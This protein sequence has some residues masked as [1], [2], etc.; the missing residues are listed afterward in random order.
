M[1][2]LV[3]SILLAFAFCAAGCG[4]QSDAPPAPRVVDGV[5][6]LSGWDFQSHGPVELNG[7]WDFYWKRFV[8]PGDFTAELEPPSRITVPGKWNGKIE[9]G[10]TLSSDGYATYRLRIKLDPAKL[11]GTGTDSL[12]AFRFGRMYT[13]YTLYLNGEQLA[14][15]GQIGSTAAQGRPRYQIVMQTIVVTEP[16]LDLVL[17]I[18]NY[19][20]LKGGLPVALIFGTEANI[21]G[22]RESRLAFDL[23]LIGGLLVLGIY[24]L[25]LYL[26]SE[27]DRAPVLLGVFC[28]IVALRHFIDDERYVDHVFQNIPWHILHRLAYAA[29]ALAVIVMLEHIHRF[30]EREA[31]VWITRPLQA[32]ST[33]FL[34]IVLLGSPKT[35]SA[36]AIFFEITAV[37]SGLYLI[38]VV[39]FA[40]VRKRN[41]ALM[42][43]ASLLFLVPGMVDKIMFDR[44]HWSGM[45]LLP[46]G[47][48]GFLVTQTL[49][50]SK[51]FSRSFISIEKSSRELERRVA[52]RTRELQESRDE[53]TEA[54]DRAEDS[55]RAKSEFLATMSHEIRTPLN[56]IIGASQL[57]GEGELLRNDREKYVDVLI[58]AGKNLLRLINQVLDFSRLEEGQTRLAR[59]EFAP[60]ELVREVVK[61]MEI[62]AGAKGLEIQTEVELDES[63]SFI[64]DPDRITQIL[65]NLVGNAVKFTGAGRI[66]L[67]LQSL[68]DF[69]GSGDPALRFEVEDTGPGIPAEKVASI[70]DR[71]TQVDSSDSR[72]FEGTGLGLAITK[73]LVHLMNGEIQYR[74]PQSGSGSCFIVTLPAQISGADS[75]KS[76][77]ESAV[78]ASAN[79]TVFGWSPRV[80]LAEDNADNVLLIQAFLKRSGVILEIAP[81]GRKAVELFASASANPGTAYDLILMDIQ[82]PHMDGYAATRRVREIEVSQ[83]SV[84]TPIVALTANA[85]A[86]DVLRSEAAGCDAHLSKP[87]LKAVLL[88]AIQKYAR[89][90]D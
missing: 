78:S 5:I 22:G 59:I 48:F 77:D 53:L 43:V 12:Y 24:Q 10:E 56:A 80:L 21:R 2:G 79:P 47:M 15:V 11:G 65:T 39:A 76:M 29:F 27:V 88:D 51:R 49:A 82:M 50:V 58:R 35:Y 1:P 14:R 87:I 61:M 60:A 54:R 37:V 23:F 6:D 45:D 74:L 32:L 66:I 33:A 3:V 70:F 90:R 4:R 17:H 7:T 63:R 83:K 68:R 73:K 9:A 18:S 25:G 30:F 44:G 31:V 55:N 16:A 84:P 52:V 81:N 34:A 75:A 20:H 40:V 41:E 57:L 13:A 72:G 42:S 36:N 64:G 67:R 19:H 28:L 86:E 69:G 8:A 38:A 26:L 71:F 89:P 62:R 85:T 46:L